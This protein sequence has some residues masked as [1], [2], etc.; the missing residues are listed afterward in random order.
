MSEIDNSDKKSDSINDELID[1]QNSDKRKLKN[2][3][4]IIYILS[5]ILSIIIV[6]CLIISTIYFYQN[7]ESNDKGENINNKN[8]SSKEKS[9]KSDK[10]EEK[11]I[12][13]YETPYK[14]EGTLD[15]LLY[16]YHSDIIK[17]MDDYEFIRDCL[18]K[19]S[20]KMVFNSNING[21]YALDV[22][23]RVNYH[24]ILA[25]IETENGNRFGGYTS[26][27]F[28][29]DSL[30]LTSTSIGLLK[31]DTSAFLFN[32]DTKK[33]YNIKKKDTTRALDCDEYFTFCFG[34]GD[35]LLRDQF[36]TN[37][38]SSNFPDCYGDNKT[39][40]FEL[41]NG[42]ENFIIKSFEIYHVLFFSEFGDENNRM[43]V[44]KNYV[45]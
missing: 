8:Q 29:P 19:I 13:R 36:M 44:H 23:T 26:D 33:Y 7:S 16:P 45:K 35:L 34:E 17:N 1:E 37:G 30:G 14:L 5:I 25:I 20:L 18:G 9:S 2:N 32:L 27:N 15:Y 41:T 31:Q 38:G 39:E 4:K 10:L 28:S 12:I 22:H 43:G 3:S 24:H 6:I 21:D 40:K 11:N 42:E